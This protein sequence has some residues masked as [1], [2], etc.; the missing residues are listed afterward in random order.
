MKK[1]ISVLL[2]VATM[3]ALASPV[4]AS[5]SKE[6]APKSDDGVTTIVYWQYFY[7]T[8][9]NLMDELIS[10]F[11]AANPDIKVEQQT[12][13]Y[14]NYNTKV[15]S[16]VP[17]GKGPNVI[18]LYYGW[19]PT[20]MD[21]GYLQPLP[22]T[23]FSTDKVEEEF[24]P[25]VQ[26]AKFDGSYYA[27]PTAVR[28]LALFWNKDLFAEA[29][30]DPEVPP[31]TLEETRDYAIQLTK[32]DK[33][34]NLTQS[35][36][37]LQLNGQIHNWI[38]EIL[39][40]QF[41]G[42]PYSEDGQTV[43]YN[44]EA[45]YEAFKFATDLQVVDEVGMPM[46]MTD[47]VTAFKAGALAMNI[48]GSFR[49]GTLDKLEDLNYGVAPIP[50]YNGIDSNFASFWANGITSFT[51]GKE[52]EAS[53]KFLAFLTSED[54]MQRWLSAVGEL[55]AKSS[56]AMESEIL[57]NPKYGPFVEGLK[58]AHATMFYDE[59][60]Q[61]QVWLDAWDEVVLNNTSVKDA[62]DEAAAK[63]QVILDKHFKN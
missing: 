27:I 48:D 30:L 34:G 29:G 33:N 49:L 59:T 50:S 17:T 35:G 63:E 40:R 16:S 19:L 24:F 26:A 25:L 8:K 1:F 14:E 32:H 9:K 41:D 21:A 53:A 5:G 12:F 2:V 54:V 43:T 51:S 56:V 47:D 23:Y 45:G 7:E 6:E 44:S 28:S 55:P 36:F 38:R 18:N 57:N 10:E 62:V 46:F 4:F 39:I 61:R 22:D 3:A 42:A 52:L 15:A 31:Q 20:Y 11:E 37:G 58:S 60:A 13:P